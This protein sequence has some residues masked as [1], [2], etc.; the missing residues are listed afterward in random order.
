MRVC[1]L[2]LIASLFVGCG[3]KYIEVYK[4][5]RC[6]VPFPQKPTMGEDRVEN[7]KSIFIYTEELEKAL[8]VCKGEENEQSK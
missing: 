8:S 5:V 3:T 4:A 1:L 2:F 7:L 6:D